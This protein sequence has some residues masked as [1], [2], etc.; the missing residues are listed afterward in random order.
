MSR[1]STVPSRHGAELECSSKICVE[2]PD[3]RED[4]SEVAQ[5]E[6]GDVEVLGFVDARGMER[7]DGKRAEEREMARRRDRYRLAA[8]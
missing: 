8:W 6:G 3:Y 4:I 7:V 2:R 5:G 1:C